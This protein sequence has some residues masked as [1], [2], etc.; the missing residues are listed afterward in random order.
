MHLSGENCGYLSLFW[1]K[2]CIFRRFY[3]VMPR[4]KGKY[5]YTRGNSE[6]SLLTTRLLNFKA[7]PDIK[8]C[9][10]EH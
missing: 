1:Q 5:V 7:V 2:S 10:P 8:I 4:N 9:L 3:F 6:Y